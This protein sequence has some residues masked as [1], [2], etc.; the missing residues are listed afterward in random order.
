MPNYNSPT[1]KMPN[2][3]VPTF[4]DTTQNH[5]SAEK[6]LRKTGEPSLPN[7]LSTGTATAGLS[8]ELQLPF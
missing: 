2:D 6:K 3:T 8:A 7:Q 5:F 1:S 4:Y